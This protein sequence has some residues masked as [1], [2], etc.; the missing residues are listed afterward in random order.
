MRSNAARWRLEDHPEQTHLTPENIVLAVRQIFGGTIC[1]D[2]CTTPDNPVGALSFV[3]P[4]DD[5]V[6]VP[7]DL[8][9]VYCNPPYGRARERWIEKCI[10]ESLRGVPI[11]LLIPAHTDT[12]WFQKTLRYATTVCLIAG[13]LR[14]GVVR[15][16]R[17]AKAAANGRSDHCEA[18]AS[19]PSALFGFN[20]DVTATVLGW[21]PREIAEQRQR[22]P[23]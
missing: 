11:V 3:A 21:S 18:T 16:G 9:S 8:G 15:E 14:F 1:L 10:L 19:H 7:W 23:A 6:A 12:L 22:H 5:G 13:R 20:C 4:P 2:P 17:A